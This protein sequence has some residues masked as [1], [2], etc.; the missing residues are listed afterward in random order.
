MGRFWA[1]TPVLINQWLWSYAQSFK[2]RRCAPL[3][4]KVICQISRS[5][6]TNNLDCDSSFNSPMTMKWCAKLETAYKRWPYVFQGRP[7]NFNVTGDKKPSILT[8][9]ERFRTVTQVWAHRWPWRMHKAWHSIE[10]VLSCFSRSS[11]KFQVH[12]GQQNRRFWP[13]SRISEL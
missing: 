10:E 8:R 9:I 12:T 6:V 7:S 3:F 4:F 13:E 5:R 2:Y 1:V 11:V